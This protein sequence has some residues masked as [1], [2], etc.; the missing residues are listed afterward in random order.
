MRAAEHNLG[1]TDIRGLNLE[2]FGHRIRNNHTIRINFT[3]QTLAILIAEPVPGQKRS[4][5]GGVEVH[6]L[7]LVREHTNRRPSVIAEFAFSD[8]QE[9]LLSHTRA[10]KPGSG[11]HRIDLA[12]L[13]L[14]AELVFEE[15]IGDFLL[16]FP[17]SA[18]DHNTVVDM[19]IGIFAGRN[20]IEPQ[21]RN[22]RGKRKHRER[23][24]HQGNAGQHCSCFS[25]PH[26]GDTKGER[27]SSDTHSTD[28]RFMNT[29]DRTVELFELFLEL[30]RHDEDHQYAKSE[31]NKGNQNDKRVAKQSERRVHEV[32]HQEYECEYQEEC[33]NLFVQIRERK[34]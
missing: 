23:Q 11:R 7:S 24:Q 4:L 33:Q 15:S 29:T 6:N 13:A 25:A 5:V 32:E 14:V 10:K 20:F 21:R 2:L 26:I 19:C 28:V 17:H 34:E 8:S 9:R 27:R 12:A 16:R 1:L 3:R 18:A 30:A 22:N 31:H